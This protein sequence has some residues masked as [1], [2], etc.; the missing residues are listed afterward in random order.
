MVKKINKI[1]K[2]N[3]KKLA[4]NIET[5]INND[6]F[7]HSKFKHHKNKYNI[8]EMLINVIII[9]KTGISYRNVSDYTH[10][11][12]NTIYKFKLKLVKYNIFEKLFN[13]TI[14]EYISEM[15]NNSKQYYTDTTFVCNKLGEDLVSYNPQVKY[16]SEG[17]IFKLEK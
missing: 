4:N 3:I 2:I 15:G 13:K 5:F 11:N 7:I 1:N 6:P 14:N 10:I 17:F 8:N 12:W 16:K 9:L